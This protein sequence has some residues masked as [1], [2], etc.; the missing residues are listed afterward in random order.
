[1]IRQQVQA[2]YSGGVIRP[3]E[4]V[5][6]DEGEEL[7]VLLMPR[8]KRR[9]VNPAEVL[10]AISALPIEGENDGF[11]GANH[12]SVLYPPAELK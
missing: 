10:R 6:L 9:R 11:T 12:D 2:V 1:M 5:I 7:D 4:T 8:Q 3:L